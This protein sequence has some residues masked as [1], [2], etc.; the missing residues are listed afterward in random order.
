MA[1]TIAEEKNLPNVQTDNVDIFD[2]EL[3]ENFVEDVS[4]KLSV[5]ELEKTAES[6]ENPKGLDETP[7]SGVSAGPDIDPE[8]LKKFQDYVK[9]LPRDKLMSL[10]SNMS[11]KDYGLGEN[12][13]AAVSGDRRTQLKR[14]LR[15][16][17]NER[18]G[19]RQTKAV[20]KE[21]QARAQAKM[22]MLHEKDVAD[23]DTPQTNVE[24]LIPNVSGSDINH[25]CNHCNHS[26]HH[27][28][29]LIT[30]DT[31]DTPIDLPAD[32]KQSDAK[33][34]DAK[35]PDSKRIVANTNATNA[36][37]VAGRRRVVKS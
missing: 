5:E 31:K 1:S 34:P 4:K 10:F 29:D 24:E 6:F 17:Q 30:H 35:Q 15:A 23:N 33:Q 28:H 18:R 11:G 20:K 36:K 37:K 9:T 3:D 8:Q 12:D 7:G 14:R 21:R 26:E 2:D 16:Q 27:V 22:T 13:L 19:S 25:N 32:A